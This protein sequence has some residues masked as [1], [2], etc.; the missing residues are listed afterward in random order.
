MFLISSFK[1]CFKNK[2]CSAMLQLLSE[3]REN[4]YYSAN[5]ELKPMTKRIFKLK[6]RIDIQIFLT[7]LLMV[8]D[9]EK[10]NLFWVISIQTSFCRFFS[11]KKT[12]SWKPYVR[13]KDRKV[14][15]LTAAYCSRSSFT[16]YFTPILFLE[17]NQNK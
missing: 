15:F 8:F 3:V 1:V 12:F 7:H 16:V 14:L 17:I 2:R 4:K 6:L 5:I 13:K 11:K 9:D 10:K